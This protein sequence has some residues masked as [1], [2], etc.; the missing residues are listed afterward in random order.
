MIPF[1]KLTLQ[2]A[3]TISFRPTAIQQKIQIRLGPLDDGELLLQILSPP[4]C[5]G[6]PNGKGHQTLRPEGN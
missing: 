2:I 5:R 6:V 3:K 4:F 1:V